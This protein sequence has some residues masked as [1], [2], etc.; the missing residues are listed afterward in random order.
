MPL[1]VQEIDEKTDKL[2]KVYNPE[3]IKAMWQF[4]EKYKNAHED[5]KE[6]SQLS[7]SIAYCDIKK[8]DNKP[9]RPVNTK[10]HNCCEL[11]N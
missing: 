2:K 3:L 5:G 8:A 10:E 11:I 1:Y 4:I 7:F 9:D 6:L